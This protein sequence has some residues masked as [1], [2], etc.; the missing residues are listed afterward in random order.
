MSKILSEARQLCEDLPKEDVEYDLKQVR[1]IAGK[2]E[3]VMKH[4]ETVVKMA[5]MFPR[6]LAYAE[7]R[8]SQAIQEHAHFIQYR[9][10]KL[11]GRHEPIEKFKAFAA[12]ELDADL[13]SWHRI[14]EEEKAA[15]RYAIETL[16][17]RAYYEDEPNR[18]CIEKATVL[19][20]LL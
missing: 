2:N 17:D 10:L 9:C 11:Y 16:R 5:D 1:V 19:R 18:E 12:S 4:I 13:S 3:N 7:M 20:G 14:T 15:I 8:E 6:L